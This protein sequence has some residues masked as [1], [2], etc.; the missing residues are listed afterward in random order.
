[1]TVE[2]RESPGDLLGH[3]WD[4]LGKPGREH[5]VPETIS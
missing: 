3:P 4:T 1:M 2:W 5:R